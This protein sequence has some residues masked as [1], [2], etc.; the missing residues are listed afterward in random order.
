VIGVVSF[1][2][3]G[4]NKGMIGAFDSHR[5]IGNRFHLFSPEGQND[6]LID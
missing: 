5:E 3:K 1:P 2:L 6:D 4:Q